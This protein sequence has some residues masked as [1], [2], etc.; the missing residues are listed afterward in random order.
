MC[1]RYRQLLATPLVALAFA[2][3][4]CASQ[5]KARPK[6]RPGAQKYLQDARAKLDANQYTEARALLEVARD[7]GAP[8]EQTRALM[9]DVERHLAQRA[10]KA[11]KPREAFD[12]RAK[13][14]QLEPA[15]DKRFTDLMAAVDTGR[16]AGVMATELAPLATKAVALKTSSHKAQKLAAQLWD[17]AGKPARALPYYQ[18]LHKVSPDDTAVGLR[19]G[20]LYVGAHRLDDAQRLFEALHKAHPDHVIAALKLADVYARQSDHGQATKL[21]E[22]LLSAHPHNTGV[23]FT[24]ARYLR[25]QGDAK[26]AQQLEQRARGAMPTVKHRKM[27]KLR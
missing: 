7:E 5:P 14:A 6:P 9:A 12:H 11:N 19:L 26:R 23:L 10:A 18:W 21:Y 17:D 15:A 1:S 2:V 24:Y 13:A 20:T 3:C 27:R 25:A 16:Q 22:E 8:D 4:G